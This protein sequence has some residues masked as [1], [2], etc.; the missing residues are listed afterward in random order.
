VNINISEGEIRNAIAVALAES[1]SPEKRD[2][3]L[4]NVVRA[5]LEMK[6]SGGGWGSDQTIL[7]KAVGEM[8]RKEA[9]VQLLEVLGA[10]KP[11]VAQIVKKALGPQ[12]EASVYAKLEEALKN[13]QIGS[14]RIHAELDRET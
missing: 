3:L 10:M 2:A 8:L 4:R 13:V 1:F 14:I 11:R 6:S 7:D 9:E 5:H 12:F